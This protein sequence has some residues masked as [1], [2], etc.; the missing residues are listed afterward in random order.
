MFC[1]CRRVSLLLKKAN[2]YNYY[3]DTYKYMVKRLLLTMS[4]ELWALLE[5]RRAEFG[6]MSVQEVINDVMRER[7]FSAVKKSKAGR[8]HKIDDPYLEYFSRKR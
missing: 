3:R 2:I 7:I 8:P 1:I 5:K 6:F 4:D